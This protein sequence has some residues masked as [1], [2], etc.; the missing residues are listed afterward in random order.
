LPQETIAFATEVT[1]GHQV[2]HDG[3]TS[4]CGGGNHVGSHQRFVIGMGR[5][6]PNGRRGGSEARTRR[7]GSRIARGDTTRNQ[8]KNAEK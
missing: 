5:E 8:G 6:Y 2:N 3:S 4:T 1:V 7:K